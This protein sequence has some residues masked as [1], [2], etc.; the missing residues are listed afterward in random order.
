MVNFVA[1]LV[2]SVC[3]FRFK[4]SALIS[5]IFVSRQVID[6]RANL[7]FFSAY[8]VNICGLFTTP[9]FS[10]AALLGC[11][12]LYTYT[13]I[14]TYYRHTRCMSDIMF[15]V[16]VL[17]Y[18]AIVS[19]A[20]RISLIMADLLVLVVTWKRAAGTMR[21]AARAKIR[22][23]LSEVLIRDGERHPFIWLVT[24]ALR[25]GYD[26]NVGTFFFL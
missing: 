20:T 12:R 17:I 21:E 11:V 1:N 24:R 9:P 18:P 14:R 13:S 4:T 5:T 3:C 16:K 26:A 8:P 22:V 23:P 15:M 2:S 10:A 6:V 7:K 25:Y 19:L